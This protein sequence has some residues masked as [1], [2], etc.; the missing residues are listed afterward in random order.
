MKFD[1]FVKSFVNKVEKN[2]IL[3]VIKLKIRGQNE[4]QTN[5]TEILDHDLHNA[6]QI[7]IKVL[8]L[9][10]TNSIQ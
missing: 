8:N 1:V 2:A 10:L 4:Q 7:I 5:V 6:A 3:S 9:T